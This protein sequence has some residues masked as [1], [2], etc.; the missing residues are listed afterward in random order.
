MAIGCVVRIVFLASLLRE[1]LLVCCAQL[2]HGRLWAVSSAARLQ[3]DIADGNHCFE[4]AAFPGPCHRCCEDTRPAAFC[5]K[6][7]ATLYILKPV[8]YPGILFGRGGVQQIPLR[9]EDRE[10]GDLGAVAP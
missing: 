10:N 4:F 7:P 5:P 2:P 1:G 3:A 6:C 8:A 9:T